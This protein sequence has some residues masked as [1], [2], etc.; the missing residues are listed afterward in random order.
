MF[1]DMTHPTATLQTAVAQGLRAEAARQN[2]SRRQLAE[3]MGRSHN[4]VSRKFNGTT[5]IT[6]DDLQ[7]LADALNV[8][9]VSLVVD[10]VAS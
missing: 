10:V 4:W 1:H 9:V 5:P 2:I 3:R 6:V 7:E 8:P